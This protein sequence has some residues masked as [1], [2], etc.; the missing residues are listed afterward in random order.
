M[1]YR[2]VFEKISTEF[3]GILRVFVNFAALRRREISE[4]LTTSCAFTLYELATK[5]LH[6]ATIFL[7]LVAKRRPEDFFN[8]EPCIVWFQKLSIPP[9]RKRFFL[10]RPQHPGNSSQVSY[11]YLNFWAFENPPPPRNFQSLLWGEYG[12]Y[13][14]PHIITWCILTIL[15]F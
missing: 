4:A 8:F 10:R 9:P 1:F 11:I 7:Q 3:H 14:E 6:L 13:L 15:V 12:Y 5:N 2:H